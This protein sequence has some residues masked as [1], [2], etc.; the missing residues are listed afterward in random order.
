MFEKIIASAFFPALLDIGKTLVYKIFKIEAKPVSVDDRIK[1]MNAQAEYVKAIASLESPSEF[2]SRWINNLR[3]SF[4]YLLAGFFFIF[5]AFYVTFGNNIQI[6][7]IL[8]DIDSIIFGFF[9]GDR[10]Y[11]HLKG[12]EK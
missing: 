11:Y 8:L 1:L 4:R 2:V 6:T 9:F 10:V 5:S 12:K 7:N 3:A